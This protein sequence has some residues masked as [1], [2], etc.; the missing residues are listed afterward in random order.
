MKKLGEVIEMN[1]DAYTNTVFITLT[2]NKE[3]AT[4]DLS[5]MKKHTTNFFRRL[6][7][8]FRKK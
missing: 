1:F 2:L 6:K 7:Y 3:N 8:R 5:I 4:K